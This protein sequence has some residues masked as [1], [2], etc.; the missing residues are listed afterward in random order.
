VRTLRRREFLQ[1]GLA[2]SSALALG[3]SGGLL[4]LACDGSEGPAGVSWPKVLLHGF[5][6]FDGIGGRLR[7]DRLIRIHG[8][9]IQAVE[10]ARGATASEDYREID[11]GG[12]TLLPGLIDAHC[13]L[14]V[15]FISEVTFAV[16]RE[17]SEQIALNFRACVQSGV[18]TVRDLGAFP[19]RLRAFRERANRNE[20][21]G[22]RVVS[23]LSPIAARRDDAMGP[24]E[25]APYFTNPLVKWLLG[26]NYAERPVSEEEIRAACEAMV[27]LGAEWLKT[28]HQEHSYSR[29]PRPLPNH[30]DAGYRTILEVGRRHGI[31]CAFHQTLVSGFEKGV[32]LGFDTLEHIPMDGAIPDESIDV[33]VEQD[34]AIVPTIMAIGDV[35]EQ[36]QVLELIRARG[37]EFLMPEPARQIR[38]QIEE[39]LA[40]GDRELS[41]EERRALVF[42]RRY[43]EQNFPNV[44]ANVQALRRAGAT[45]GIGTDNGGTYT[46]LFGRYVRELRHYVEAGF[47]PLETL[48]IATAG[49]ARILGMQD[50]IGTIEAGKLADLVAVEGNPLEDISAIGRV[51]LVA[52][53][54]IFLRSDGLAL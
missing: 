14:T 13:H 43:E 51:K 7:E 2:A 19:A 32:R 12:A 24:P 53:G 50:R 46:G 16:L 21:A 54:G 40:Q 29:F 38:A 37:A 17:M 6:L 18:T 26:G 23:S 5:R 39:S 44:V 48:R 45:L 49:N 27:D 36:E 10:P 15:P 11:L 52:K 9:M 20:I 31:R 1:Q 33:F 35:F 4:S 47:S 22:P 28:L 34:M 30:S 8:D 41:P 25:R 42:D 3:A